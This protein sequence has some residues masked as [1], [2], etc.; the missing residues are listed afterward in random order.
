MEIGMEIIMDITMAI[1]FIFTVHYHITLM[2]TNHLLPKLKVQ[3]VV[4]VLALY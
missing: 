2:C 4:M 1:Q 3:Q